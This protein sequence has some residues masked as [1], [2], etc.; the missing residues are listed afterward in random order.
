MQGSTS[1]LQGVLQKGFISTT[2]LL[3]VLI[4]WNALSKNYHSLILPS[5]KE[6]FEAL[7]G[8]WQS[9]ELWASTMIT[10]RRTMV[11]YA[12]ALAGGLLFALLLRASGFLQS[13]FRP[14]ITVIQIIPPVIWVVLAVIWFGIADDL[15]PIFL[16]FIVTFPIVFLTIF[17]GLESVDVRLV[18]MATFYRC[19]QHEIIRSIYLPTLVPHF[20]S[21]V[22]LGLSFAWKSTV[23][24]E[25][26]GSSSGIGFAISMANAN[27][28]TEKLFAWA[29][30]L[31]LIMLVFEYGILSFVNQ[32]M[33]RWK[34]HG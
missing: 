22:S 23:F 9:G 1:K 18:E 21:A 10:F 30:V 12:A 14:V 6:T 33:T 25:F 32:K 2:G 3:V 15:T 26:I 13:V 28:E 20:L 5:P 4:L 34:Q 24:A 17:S 8:L 19:S 27:L 11:G 16:I 29:I 7:Q 31:I